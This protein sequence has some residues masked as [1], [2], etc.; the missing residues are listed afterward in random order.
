VVVVSTHCTPLRHSSPAGLTEESVVTIRLRDCQLS[1]THMV[2]S[3]GP[4]LWGERAV[5]HR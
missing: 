4:S 5:P 1:C 3:V 2:Q